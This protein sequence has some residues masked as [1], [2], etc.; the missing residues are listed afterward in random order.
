MKDHIHTQMT[1]VA[2]RQQIRVSTIRLVMVSVSDGQHDNPVSVF[3]FFKIALGATL[4]A[5]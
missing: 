1:G 4:A 3:R 5:M 2:H